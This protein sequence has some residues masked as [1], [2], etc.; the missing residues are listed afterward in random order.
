MVAQL[1]ELGASER[2]YEV[3]RDAVHGHDIRQVD[4][5]GGRRRKLDL[6][7]LGSLLQTLQSHRILTQI[8]LVLG[9]ERLGHIVDQD[10]VEVV[11]AQMGVAVGRL[12]LE[13]TVAQFENR[14][15]ESTAAQVVNGHLHIRILL[16]QTISQSRGR[17]LVDDAAHL[18][19][20]DLARLL[21]GLT[22]RIREIGGHGDNRLAHLLTQIILGSL[23]HL[24]EDDGRDLLRGILTAVDIHAGSVVVA[25]DD[26]IGSARDVSRDLVVLLAHET[27][28]RENCS[29]GIGDSLSL[30]RVAHLTLRVVG[31]CH[32]RRCGAVSLRVGDNHG[33]VALHYRYA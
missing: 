24:L 31:K 32:Y 25:L 8:D 7:L 10:M 28:D 23:L 12:N 33:L 6:G 11:A 16:V 21:G 22:L 4:L 30:G 3:L 14:D 29:L 26:R 18:Q 1:L 20:R 2:H 13:H 9:L 17:R 19:A 15:I 5:R 27:L